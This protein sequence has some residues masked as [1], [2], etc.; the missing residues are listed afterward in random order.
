MRAQGSVESP[1]HM[2]LNTTVSST[3]SVALNNDAS[4]KGS[5]I[6][7]IGLRLALGSVMATVAIG[8][9]VSA[10]HPTVTSDARETGDRPTHWP[11][12]LV[13]IAHKMR[14]QVATYTF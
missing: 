2:R 7:L 10:S 14:L 9:F 11:G 6:R 3:V 8:L 12:F 1:F 4:N 5:V 13:G